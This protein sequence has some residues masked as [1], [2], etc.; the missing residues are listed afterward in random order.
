M[1]T[2]TAKRI[3]GSFFIRSSTL[4]NNFQLD[5]VPREIKQDY[6]SIFLLNLYSENPT[7][8]SLLKIKFLVEHIRPKNFQYWNY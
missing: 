5:L 8:L 3:I 4:T 1:E 2:D 7:Y 6:P